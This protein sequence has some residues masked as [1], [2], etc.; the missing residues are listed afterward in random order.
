VAGDA[1]YI[2]GAVNE[3]TLGV[4][5]GAT[6]KEET[7]GIVMGPASIDVEPMIGTEP[8]E[9]TEPTARMCCGIG[10]GIRVGR[11]AAVTGLN[12]GTAPEELIPKKA[13]LMGVNEAADAV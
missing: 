9:D 1:P 8:M 12:G 5:A 4:I 2:I 13:V 11:M 10:P 3:P 6:I 7:M